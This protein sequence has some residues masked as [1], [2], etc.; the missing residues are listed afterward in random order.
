MPESFTRVCHRHKI[1]YFSAA[2]FSLLQKATLSFL[3]LLFLL[4]MTGDGNASVIIVTANVQNAVPI[5][6][7]ENISPAIWIGAADLILGF[8]CTD[9]NGIADFNNAHASITGVNTQDLNNIPYVLSGAVAIISFDINSYITTRGTYY[10]TPFCTDDSNGTGAG[11]KLT[12]EY[13]RSIEINVQFPVQDANINSNPTITFDVNKNASSDVNKY[14]I[15]IDLNGIASTAFDVDTDCIEFSGEFYCNY[16]E[17]GL[18]VDADNN[19]VFKASDDLNNWATSIERLVHYDAIAPVI[20]TISAAESGSSVVFSWNGQDSFTGI[21]TY[22]IREDSESWIRTGLAL[23]HVFS[24]SGSTSHIYYVKARDYADNNSLI[25]QTT[26]TPPGPGPTPTPTPSPGPGGGG[27]GAGISPLPPLEDDFNIVLI[28]IDDPVEVGEKLDF[29]YLVTNGTRSNDNAYIEYWLE[30]DG[31]K[32]VSGSETV[33]LVSGERREINA[34][35]LLFDDMD[36]RYEFHLQL[37]KEGQ[38]NVE[39]ERVITVGKGVPT[40]IGL[41][42]MSLFP[43]G[44]TEP[45]F[46]SI[47]VESNKDAV[48]PILINERLYL[49][50]SLV[51]EKKQTVAVQ[52]FDKFS[53]EVYGL[54]PGN[55]Q[56]EVDAIYQGEIE[57]VQ[58]SFERKPSAGMLPLIPLPPAIESIASSFFGLFFWILAAILAVVALLFLAK[59]LKSMKENKF[60]FK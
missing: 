24:G 6:F 35:L 33:Y 56:L 55:Y 11:T 59:K 2:T 10:V 49:E 14:S 58:H 7:D 51:W 37:S 13:V 28:R 52:V 39:V 18:A 26:Y 40:K 5:V 12:G 42:L 53:E 47:V 27:G 60:G 25:V 15:Q 32:F 46:F 8:Q 31:L 45:L 22:Y 57:T 29:T 17:T 4:N 3:L 30:R 1:T 38:E 48:L 21:E 54:E 36:G 16:I 23:S 43:N 19:I 41:E 34:N 50:G 9:P 44:G 20:T